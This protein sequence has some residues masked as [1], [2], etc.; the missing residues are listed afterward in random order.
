MCIQIPR[1]AQGILSIVLSS[2]LGVKTNK[3][4][5]YINIPRPSKGLR[6]G[7]T[8]ECSLRGYVS[9]PLSGTQKN[10]T[11]YGDNDVD[12]TNFGT[13]GWRRTELTTK[14]LI[15]G[16]S[17]TQMTRDSLVETPCRQALRGAKMTPLGWRF[18]TPCTSPQHAND[19]FDT[20]HFWGAK[21][22]LKSIASVGSDNKDE[23]YIPDDP[24]QAEK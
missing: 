6:F 18:G 1:A 13:D 23:M 11:G 17:D 10:T 9:T 2:Q 8:I 15:L 22:K 4:Y 19:T 24:K 3:T 21:K 20:R 5:I 7:T 12:S 16:N 14:T